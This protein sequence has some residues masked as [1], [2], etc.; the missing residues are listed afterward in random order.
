MLAEADR[1]GRFE[2]VRGDL[3]DAALIDCLFAKNG[4]DVVVNLAAQAGVRYSIENP[5]VIYRHQPRRVLQRA[6]VRA[7][8]HPGRSTL[9]YASS[10]SVYGGNE[11]VPFS[12]GRPRRCA[13]L[14]LRR[15]QEVQRA[16]WPAAYSKL[17]SIPAT[18]LRFFTVYGPMGRPDMAYFGFADEAEAGARP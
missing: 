2:L 6:G 4:F 15:H 13:R 8:S 16:R 10:T 3:C 9:V 5:R 12:G 17:Y 18:G 14:P 11:R 1:D 7:A